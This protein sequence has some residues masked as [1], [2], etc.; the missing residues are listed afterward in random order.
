MKTNRPNFFPKKKHILNTTFKTKTVLSPLL[1][2]ESKF[3]TQTDTHNLNH[4]N[5][6][7]KTKI[8]NDTVTCTKTDTEICN[9]IEICNKTEISNLNQISNFNQ[10]SDLIQPSDLNQIYSLLNFMNDKINLRTS[11]DNF[12]KFNLYYYKIQDTKS[13]AKTGGNSINNSWQTRELS[14]IKSDDVQFVQLNFDSS[15]TIQSGKYNIYASSTFY[16]TGTTKLRIY[17]TN[18]QT[19]LCESINT[20]VSVSGHD[21]TNI[22]INDYINVPENEIFNVVLQYYCEYNI[23]NNGLGIPCN[24]PDSQEIY[25]QILITKLL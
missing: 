7:N 1:N 13:F 20:Y 14:H 23:L 4:N 25:S 6:C 12:I 24:F 5:T 11:P 16:N 22:I 3:E 10:T 8:C 19:T 15:I 9:K 21:N 2:T 17:E 18:T